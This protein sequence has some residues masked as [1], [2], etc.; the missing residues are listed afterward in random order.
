MDGRWR[1]LA[2]VAALIFS[3]GCFTRTIYIPSGKT[4]RLRQDI[5]GIKIW[6]KDSDGKLVPGLLDL[7]EGWYV[8]PSEEPAPMKEGASK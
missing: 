5:K 7:H 4:V 8:V 2:L 1:L 3:A 6:A